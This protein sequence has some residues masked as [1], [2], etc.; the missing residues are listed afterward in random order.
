MS[1]LYRWLYLLALLGLWE[2]I[3][4]RFSYAAR[5][6]EPMLINRGQGGRWWL[7]VGTYWILDTLVILT[8]LWVYRKPFGLRIPTKFPFSQFAI[9]AA[10]LVFLVHLAWLCSDRYVYL[11]LSS[12]GLGSLWQ[13]CLILAGL[14]LLVSFVRFRA[15]AELVDC[16]K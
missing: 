13:M 6:L 8:I 16:I 14:W 4:N 12:I 9:D 5:T 1:K 3:Y 15:L 7:I 11:T 2:L 10:V